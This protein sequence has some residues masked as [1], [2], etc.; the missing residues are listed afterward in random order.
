MRYIL[1]FTLFLSSA[2]YSQSYNKMDSFLIN[3]STESAVSTETAYKNYYDIYIGK[4]G[5]DTCYNNL[6]IYIEDAAYI[7]DGNVIIIDTVA[8]IKQLLCAVVILAKANSSLQW[9]R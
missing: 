6:L 8:T 5:K 9:K 4:S 1:I 3:R 7:R 2:C